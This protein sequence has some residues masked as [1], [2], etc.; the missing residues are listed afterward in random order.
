MVRA[1]LIVSETHETILTGTIKWF[2]VDRGFI[3]TDDYRDVF[4]HSSQVVDHGHELSKC[5]RVTFV[6]DVGR[7]GRNL[8]RRI[9]LVK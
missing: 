9:E 5:E 3:T 6:E 7:Y 2:R 8:A 1:G 4:C